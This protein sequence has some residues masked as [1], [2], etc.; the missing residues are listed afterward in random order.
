MACYHPLDAYQLVTGE[1]FFSANHKGSTRPDRGIKREFQL[2]CG[3]CIGCRITRQRN[4]AIRCMHEA[5]LHEHSC[6]ITLTYDDKNFE[7]SLRYDDFQRF[8]KRLRKKI[9]KVRFYACGEY[10]EEYRRPHFHAILFGWWPSDAQYIS[11]DKF[12]SKT[13]RDVWG[14]GNTS[15][16]NVTYESAAYVAGYVLKKV[17]GKRAESHYETTDVRTGEIIQLEPEMGKMSLKPGIGRL[18]FEKYWKEVYGARDGVV[19]KG[20]FMY[21][22]PKYYDKLLDMIP[23]SITDRIEIDRYVR[24]KKFI[25][26]S[27]P[28]RLQTRELV[29]KA[30]YNLKRRVL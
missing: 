3:Q 24:N 9:G 27:S 30:K 28:D 5:S 16:G 19:M 8:M 29:A 17:T 12:E 2:P 4:W 7:P 15:F 10:G 22:A 21:P 20:G 6:F 18:W 14:L 23:S 11:P 26:D 25:E 13:L 1:V